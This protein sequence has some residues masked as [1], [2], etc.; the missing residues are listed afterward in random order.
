MEYQDRVEQEAEEE[1]REQRMATAHEHRHA[2]GVC[3]ILAQTPPEK[4]W[5][6]LEGE[7]GSDSSGYDC[8][9]CPECGSDRVV[10]THD[11][12][13]EC[14]ECGH[15]ELARFQVEETDD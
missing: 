5:C 15:R 8:H 12:Y 13:I 10:Y 1:R 14:Q 11:T 2:P 6:D 9:P 7:C 4:T 3:D